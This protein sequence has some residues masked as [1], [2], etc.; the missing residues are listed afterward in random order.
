MTTTEKKLN[1]NRQVLCKNHIDNCKQLTTINFEG[2]KVI[3][4]DKPSSSTNPGLE[5]MFDGIK[6]YNSGVVLGGEPYKF[7]KAKLFSNSYASTARNIVASLVLYHRNKVNKMMEIHIPFEKNNS[8]YNSLM[9]FN[10]IL[11]SGSTKT[12]NK[13]LKLTTELTLN[14]IVPLNTP[15]YYVHDAGSDKEYIFFDRYFPLSINNEQL[16]EIR[17]AVGENGNVTVNL[18]NNTNNTNKIYYSNTGI[19]SED[20][21]EYS[22]QQLDCE[23]IEIDGEPVEPKSDKT[24]ADMQKDSFLTVYEQIFKSDFFTVILGILIAL[25][26]FAIMKNILEAINDNNYVAKLTGGLT[27]NRG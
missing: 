2:S 6:K 22:S 7:E 23:A 20:L 5:I 12:K 1:E 26:A 13:E 3:K 9:W 27:G 10:N 11:Y 16:K 18:S 15:Y 14:D 4:F 24:D 21:T 8:Y 25:I 17:A 19:P